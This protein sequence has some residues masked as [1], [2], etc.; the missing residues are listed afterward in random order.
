MPTPD[1]INPE[2]VTPR[3]PHLTIDLLRQGWN[4]AKDKAP[5]F[6]GQGMQ[7]VEDFGD[8]T[9]LTPAL[10][11]AA[12]TL[13][14]SDMTDLGLSAL[15]PASKLG[16]TAVKAVG[17]ATALAA[18]TQDA[19]AATGM[20]GVLYDLLRKHG[21][22]VGK[23]KNDLAGMAKAM[24]AVDRAQATKVLNFDYP[25]AV[26]RREMMTQP[27]APTLL[28]TIRGMREQKYLTP[29]EAFKVGDT[30][31]PVAGDTTRAGVK[32][33]RA[34]VDLRNPVE[35][36]GG[37][38]YGLANPEQFP[39]AS[40]FSAA[41]TKQK[42]FE[43]AADQYGGDV[44]G[45]HVAM[46]PQ[47]SHFSKHAPELWM[48]ML[49]SGA[50]I[51]QNAVHAFD[52]DVLRELNAQQNTFVKRV[53]RPSPQLTSAMDSWQGVLH[54]DT[55][56]ALGSNPDLRKAM[57]ATAD[58]PGH[59]HLGFPDM[60]QFYGAALDPTLKTGDVGGAVMHAAPGLPLMP[61]EGSHATYGFNLPGE[62]LGRLQ[63]PLPPEMAF[64]ET[65]AKFPQGGGKFLGSLRT[66]HWA[67]PV[68]QQFIDQ[69]SAYTQAR[70]KALREGG[71]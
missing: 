33:K 45:V 64:P 52:K 48:E 9:S 44:K 27:Q 53:G 50:P 20:R 66:A 22:D 14:P 12:E 25:E 51:E 71:P 69:A 30:I 39:W 59:Q 42:S 68:D 55:P 6:V 43:R 40:E 11:G 49:R 3:K 62:H 4:A 47:G 70:L 65:A 58:K 46:A 24:P 10:Q 18:G 34:G 56:A 28:E 19:E 16:K 23:A 54:P 57:L 29:E 31:V 60:E 17:G 5:G 36:Q 26:V 21:G 61:T 13:L 1:G 67:R 2:F 8:R 41:N 37:H 38:E 15:G 35:L 63:V 7:A 32:V